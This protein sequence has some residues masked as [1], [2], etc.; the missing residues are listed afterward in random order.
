MDP[1]NKRVDPGSNFSEPVLSRRFLVLGREP[2]G[3]TMHTPTGMVSVSQ[4]E[5]GFPLFL[6][7]DVSVAV[8]LF[9]HPSRSPSWRAGRGGLFRNFGSRV[10]FCFW[11]WRLMTSAVVAQ[12]VFWGVLFVDLGKRIAS[13]FRC[14]WGVGNQLMGQRIWN[15]NSHRLECPALY[16]AI[17]FSCCCSNLEIYSG[18]D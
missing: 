12:I 6:V 14:W 3:R 15:V 4:S 18:G 13:S 7:L 5:D 2:P 9:F 8:S 17:L 16:S 10:E 1:C 11:S